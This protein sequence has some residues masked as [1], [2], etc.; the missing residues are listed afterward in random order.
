M[1]CESLKLNRQKN[2]INITIFSLILI[3]ASFLISKWKLNSRL[4]PSYL[5]SMLVLFPTKIESKL[6]F[7]SNSL[8]SI[9]S[10]QRIVLKVKT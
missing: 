8:V 4:T 10:Y 5:S 9:L 6:A 1:N 2:D 7:N 3:R